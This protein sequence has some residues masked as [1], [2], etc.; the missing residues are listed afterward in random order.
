MFVFFVSESEQV[1]GAFKIRGAYN[2][3]IKVINDNPRAKELGFTTASSG[4]HA[5]ACV[6]D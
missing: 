1:T 6:R 2:K 5:K 4:N 3:V